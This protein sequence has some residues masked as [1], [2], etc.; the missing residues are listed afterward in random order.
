MS[1]SVCLF[2][3]VYGK[4]D[5]VLAKELYQEVSSYIKNFRPQSQHSYVFLN[6]GGS[7]LSGMSDLLTAEFKKAGCSKRYIV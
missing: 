5:I 3:G 2:S 1:D 6:W 4:A 7:T